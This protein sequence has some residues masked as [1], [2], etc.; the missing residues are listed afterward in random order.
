MTRESFK[1]PVNM[2]RYGSHIPQKIDYNTWD[3]PYIDTS[4]PKARQAVF[5]NNPYRQRKKNI[6]TQRRSRGFI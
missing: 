4:L 1:K 6:D 3:Q 5:T 2:R